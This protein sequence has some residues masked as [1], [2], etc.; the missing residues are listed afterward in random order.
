MKPLPS[1]SKT[2]KASISSSSVSV[3]CMSIA[4]GCQNCGVTRRVERSVLH[5]LQCMQV[6]VYF[7]LSTYLALLHSTS[8]GLSLL[9][10]CYISSTS[11][12]HLCYISV[13]L[14]VLHL[15]SHQRQELREVNGSVPVSIDLVNHVLTA[16]V[17]VSSLN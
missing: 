15:A 10:L 13:Y 11:L 14:C 8:L 1:R 17:C 4:C 16:C 7:Q 6:T 3:S 9:Q 2:L 5:P 12:L